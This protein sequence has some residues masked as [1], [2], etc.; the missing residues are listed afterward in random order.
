MKLCYRVYNNLITNLHIYTYIRTTL[1][2]FVLPAALCAP[3]SSYNSPQVF[4][5]YEGTKKSWWASHL[6]FPYSS[7]FLLLPP[8]PIKKNLDRMKLHSSHKGE[9]ES[10]FKCFLTNKKK[11][12]TSLL[13]NVLLL[14]LSQ[15][16]KFLLL[17]YPS[18]LLPA[19]KKRN[20]M[21]LP[22]EIFHI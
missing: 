3:I 5:F 8:T 10:C 14:A 12:F 2:M 16:K 1:W 18:L 21:K 20:L 15:K 9:E 6:F 22:S 19:K 13:L 4:I 11:K 17:F 7:T